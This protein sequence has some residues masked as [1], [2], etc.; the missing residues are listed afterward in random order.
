MFY[1]MINKTLYALIIDNCI[2]MIFEYS[3]HLFK[4]MIIVYF[5]NYNKHLNTLDGIMW[6]NESGIIQ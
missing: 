3:G 6:V 2:W 5:Q 1:C 4:V